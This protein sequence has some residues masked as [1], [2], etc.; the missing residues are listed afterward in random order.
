MKK[1]LALLLMTLAL[2]GCKSSYDVTLSNGTQFTGVSKPK[3]DK[4]TGKYHFKTPTG[5][6][7]AFYAENIRL[8]EPHRDAYEFRRTDQK[9]K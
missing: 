1:I 8:I 7:G 4:K 9:K 5:R 3:L 6:E 2:A